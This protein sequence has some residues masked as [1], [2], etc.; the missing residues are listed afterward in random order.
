MAYF[1]KRSLTNNHA[2]IQL[3]T[4]NKC[5]TMPAIKRPDGT[6]QSILRENNSNT[7]TLAR[8]FDVELKYG[9]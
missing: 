1:L 5:D 8:K 3:I 2:P 4:Q 6:P 7:L 9:R